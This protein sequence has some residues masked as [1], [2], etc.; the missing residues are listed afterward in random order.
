MVKRTL[1]V[2]VVGSLALAGCSTGSDGSS[3]VPPEGPAQETVE[4]V[5][6]SF[7]FRPKT[8]RLPAGIDRIEMVGEG[9]V[10]T[11]L[12]EGVKDLALRV[13]GEERT[14]TLVELDP[15]S[16]T[17]YC[18]VPGHRDEGMEGTIRVT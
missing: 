7:F 1:G 18:D 6:G 14:A 15:G 8:L 13:D 12:I 16:Y 5:A 17:F 3:Y 9:G 2:L 4:V 11:L 10:H